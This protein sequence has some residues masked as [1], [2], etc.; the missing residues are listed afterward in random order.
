MRSGLE[1]SLSYAKALLVVRV[2]R[3]PEARGDDHRPVRHAGPGDVRTTIDALRTL[4]G[5]RP[6][7]T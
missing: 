7:G 6:A 1:A 2:L 3:E 5:V 4:D